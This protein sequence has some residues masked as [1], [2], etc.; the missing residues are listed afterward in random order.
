MI[1]E[2]VARHFQYFFE[3]TA[4]WSWTLLANPWRNGALVL[5]Y[6]VF[7]TILLTE[8]AVRDHR[9]CLLK[10]GK[11]WDKYCKLVPWKILPG[12]Y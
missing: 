9:K 1:Q 5:F 11:H 3:L 2:C 6:S 12:V 10:Y 8:R 4:A 7:L